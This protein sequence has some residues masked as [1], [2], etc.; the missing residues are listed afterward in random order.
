[1]KREANRLRTCTVVA[2][3][4]STASRDPFVHPGEA[5]RVVSVKFA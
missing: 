4:R 1:V 2:T 3:A 5:I